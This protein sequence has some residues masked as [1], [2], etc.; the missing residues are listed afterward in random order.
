MPPRIRIGTIGWN[1]PEWR[2]T[3]YAPKAK[4]SDLLTQY[5]RRF[6]IV[7]AASAGYGMPRTDVVAA[8]AA[9]TPDDFEISLKVP[10]WIV[11]KKAGD[12]D[13]PRALDVLLTHL[14]PL[15]DAGKLGTLVAQFHPSFRR[16]KKMEHLASFVHAL[17]DG[18]RWAVE[19]RDA[20]WWHAETYHLLTESG[21]TLVWSA[22][23]SGFRTPPVATTSALYL[24]LLG[25]RDLEAPFDAK[26][27]DAGAELAH[28]AE[29][30]QTATP[31]VERI[32]AF[33][34]KYLEGYAPGTA[35]TLA[36]LLGVDLRA[37]DHAPVQMTLDA[38]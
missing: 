30:I 36:D 23:G 20:S 9:K 22:L 18:P 11:R 34:S 32:D 4:P 3:V 5:A 12:P 17:P 14:A 24:R 27:R 29:H 33:V 6:P 2:G 21:V 8:W 37:S 35:E 16:D 7:E 31:S 15:R 10:D 38:L 25:E 19:L 26:R 28:W 13:L 1:Y